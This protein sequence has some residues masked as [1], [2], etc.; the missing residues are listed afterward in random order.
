VYRASLLVDPLRTT[1]LMRERA[2]SLG[3]GELF[4]VM[5][6]TFGD[7]EPFSFG[8]DAAVEFPPHA[9]LPSAIAAALRRAPPHQKSKAAASTYEDAILVS[10]SRPVPKFPWFRTVMTSW[11]NTP[12]RG[13]RGTVYLGATPDLFRRWLEEALHCTYLFHPPGDRLLFINAWNEWAEG[14]YL[15]PDASHGTA[16]LNAVRD[17]LSATTAFSVETARLMGSDSS[18]DG[19][20]AYA[21]RPWSGAEAPP[22]QRAAKT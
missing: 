2:H 7:W 17:A 3:L 11:D 22:T 13:A 4:L 19:L 16:Y 5:A 9:I 14:A 20:L 8:F 21:R 1:D 6:Q 12:R 15:E 18:P 10:L